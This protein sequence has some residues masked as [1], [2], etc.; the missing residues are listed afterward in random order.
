MGTK[1]VDIRRGVGSGS[2]GGGGLDPSAFV[3]EWTVGAG[4]TIKLYSYDT[5]PSGYTMDYDVDWGDGNTDTN[6]TTADKTHTY[7]NPGTY[8][9]V[10]TNQFGSLNME[11]ASVIE[12]SYLTKMVQWGTDNIWSS[13]YRMFYLCSDMLY[14]ATDF[15][16]LTNLVEKTDAREMFRGC[17]SIETMDIS[18]WTNTSNITYLASTFQDMSSCSSFNA[19]GLDFSNVTYFAHGLR[20]IGTSVVG[21]CDI[22]LSNITWGSLITLYF[23]FESADASSLNLSNWDF[24]GNPDVDLYF[25]FYNLDFNSALDLST[26]TNFSTSRCTY[27]FRG[28]DITS[29]DISNWDTSNVASFYGMFYSATEIEQITGLN[30]L[31]PTSVTGTGI[32]AMFHTAKKLSFTGATNNFSNAWGLGLGNCTN[33]SFMFYSTGTDLASGGDPPNVSN[34]VLTLNTSISSIFRNSKF[35]SK[36]LI[37]SWDTSALIGSQ[38]SFMYLADWGSSYTLDL[39]AWNFTNAVTSWVNGFRQVVNL[40]SLKFD[41]N[42]CDFGGVTDMSLMFYYTQQITNIEFLNATDFSSVTTF[43][44]FC[45]N[46]DALETLDLGTVQDFSSVTNWAGFASAINFTPIDM[47]WKNNANITSTTLSSLLNNSE[48]ETSD[49]DNLLIALDTVGNINGRLHSGNSNY[50]AAGAGGTARANLVTNGWT[51]TDGGGV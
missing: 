8:Q 18:N 45:T 1:I 39:S 13:L 38:G 35:N 20:G 43:S 33:L 23:T 17:S 19:S 36:P 4:D 42:N 46:T 30:E 11:R 34:W 25:T 44:N 22:N 21:G 15:P 31:D 37:E 48:I 14:E 26:W 2:G 50:T 3:T 5:T 27:T 9:V 40:T 32:Q 7:A 41:S 49:Y 12:R 51:I 29:L 10:I 24:T 6:V 16:N 47:N 28:S